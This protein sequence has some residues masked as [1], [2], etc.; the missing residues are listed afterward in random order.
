MTP[1][2]ELVNQVKRCGKGTRNGAAAEESKFGFAP[3]VL[4]FDHSRIGPGCDSG[5]LLGAESPEAA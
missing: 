4:A 3:C 5:P 2:P 1:R